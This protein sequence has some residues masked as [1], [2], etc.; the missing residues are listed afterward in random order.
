MVKN[1]P[2]I[3]HEIQEHIRREP[4]KAVILAFGG[5][6]FLCLLPV[7]KLLGF[8]AK[9]TF[10]LLKPALLILG[11]IKVLDFSGVKFEE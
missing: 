6:F 9:V 1:A 8:L 5:G 2:P 7:G 4:I 10:L 11:I 3:W